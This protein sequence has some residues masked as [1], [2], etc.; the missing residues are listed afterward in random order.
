MLA[1]GS[2]IEDMLTISA[3]MGLP[4]PSLRYVVDYIHDQIINVSED[5]MKNLKE[6]IHIRNRK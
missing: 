3:F 5:V 1:T 2:G 6:E 4:E